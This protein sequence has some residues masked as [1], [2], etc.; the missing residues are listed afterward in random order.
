M[1]KYYIM[2]DLRRVPNTEEAGKIPAGGEMY[3]G[4]IKAIISADTWQD[5]MKAGKRC[6]TGSLKKG[7]VPFNWT[8][9][10]YDFVV[11][12]GDKEIYDKYRTA[13]WLSYHR[14][15]VGMTVK[16]LADAAN[17]N[18]MQVYKADSGEIE[19]G[20]MTAR[21]LLALADALGVDIRELI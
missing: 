4:K 19:L 5:A 16:Q 18:Y 15:Q 3:A 8:W 14:V 20:N 1:K 7:V 11:E 13:T 17:V 6:I 10:E 2:A 12:N 21:N 9:Q